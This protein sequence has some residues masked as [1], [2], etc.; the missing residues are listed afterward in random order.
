MHHEQVATDPAGGELRVVE[1]HRNR[2]RYMRKHHGSVAAAAV[3]W[4]T[5][6]A[7]ALRALA[8]LALPGRSPGWYW[9]HARRALRPGTGEGLREA[10]ERRNR[11]LA[12][13][14]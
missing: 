6:W 14:A 11:E 8:A 5:A 3:R 7:Y 13:R 2:D 12:A 4:L 9:L 10:A 1:F